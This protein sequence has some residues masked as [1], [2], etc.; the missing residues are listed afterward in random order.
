MTRHNKGIFYFMLH[1]KNLTGASDQTPISTREP[2]LTEEDLPPIAVTHSSPDWFDLAQQAMQNGRLENACYYIEETLVNYRQKTEPQNLGVI[3][4]FYASLL[5]KLKDYEK[6]LQVLSEAVQRS[7]TPAVIYHQMGLICEKLARL[8]EASSY[9]LQALQLSPRDREIRENFQRIE[10]MIHLPGKLSICMLAPDELA[11][12]Q[13]NLENAAAFADEII[14]ITSANPVKLNSLQLKKSVKLVRTEWQ[15]DRSAAR[16]AALKHATG[17]WILWLDANEQIP[18]ADQEIIQNLLSAERNKAFYFH[19]YQAGTENQV[20]L[21]LRMFPNLP[22]IEFERPFFEDISQSAGNLGLH[23]VNS[24]VKITQTQPGLS[25]VADNA[26]SNLFKIIKTWSHNHAADYF[27]KF[28]LGLH[29]FK[30]HLSHSALT[31]FD[32]LIEDPECKKN[33]HFIYL[34]ALIFKAKTLIEMKNFQPAA[35]LLK[36]AKKFDDRYY[37]TFLTLGEVYTELKQPEKAMEYLKKCP[38]IAL[39][40]SIIPLNL[41]QLQG[42]W[43]FL[44]GRN[45][46]LLKKHDQAILHFK[47]ARMFLSDFPALLRVWA[48]C[49]REMEKYRDAL[50]LMESAMI[51]DAQNPLNH[52][53]MGYLQLQMNQSE[54]AEEYFNHALELDRH[55]PEALGGLALAFQLSGEFDRAIGALQKVTKLEPE[56]QANWINLGYLFLKQN[57][58]NQAEKALL[59]AQKSQPLPLNA[60]LALIYVHAQKGQ[61]SMLLLTYRDFLKKLNGSFPLHPTAVE[62]LGQPNKMAPEFLKLAVHLIS[63][64]NPDGACYA[65]LTAIQLAPEQHKTSAMLA[66]LYYTQQDFTNAIQIL[67]K[68]VLKEPQNAAHLRKLGDCYLKIKIDNAAKMCYWRARELDNLRNSAAQRMAMGG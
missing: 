54:G 53:E 33:S 66:D 68:L 36:Q 24:G 6:A 14:L 34:N 41:V 4:D 29:D 7:A 52:I 55:S 56:N 12:C 32:R 60:S 61:F 9:F 17:D 2:V 65:L 18:L 42:M 44:V 20:W 67:E 3:L 40:A 38:G 27:S 62:N 10:K 63:Q 19:F 51:L 30:L 15:N 23:L 43:Y 47:K 5:L 57:Q 64:N 48:Q 37:L 22:G 39:K 16:N 28:L 50:T 11:E 46:M 35:E 45:W 49:Y 58:I 1:K 8:P 21:Q 31:N 59:A 13:F 26:A 25:P